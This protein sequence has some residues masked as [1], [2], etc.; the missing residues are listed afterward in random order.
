MRALVLRC[1][2]SSTQAYGVSAVPMQAW[3]VT[4]KANS[5]M[6]YSL[7]KITTVDMCDT[8]LE[9]A[10]KDRESLERRRRNL[11]ETIDNFDERTVN[12]A[13]EQISVQARLETYTALYAA[14]PEG[15]DK[16]NANL[17]VKRME[18]RKAQLDKMV[19]G[20]NVFVLLDKQV[21]YNLLESQVSIADAYI[22][23]VQAKK[24]ALGAA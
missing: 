16:I 15:K 21:D 3:R 11:A 8:L 18:T 4:L 19:I 5:I 12:I 7:E 22:A 14:L 23:A 10:G 9:V 17:E 2:E 13:T 6:I 20:Y 1:F 24:T